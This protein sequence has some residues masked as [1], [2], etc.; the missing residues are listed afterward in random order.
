MSRLVFTNGTYRLFLASAPVSSLG[1]FT[2]SEL[3]YYREELAR[4][5]F[6][7][8]TPDT[9]EAASIRTWKDVYEDIK[10]RAR[11]EE[12]YVDGDEAIVTVLEF[13]SRFITP[14][15]MVFVTR[16]DIHRV[17]TRMTAATKFVLKQI[18]RWRNGQNYLI[19]PWSLTPQQ[20][21]AMVDHMV[22]PSLVTE[23]GD[24]ELAYHRDNGKINS[25]LN[26]MV[27]KVPQ[28][29]LRNLFKHT[30]DDR[31]TACSQRLHNYLK[32]TIHLNLDRLQM[33]RVISRLV[34]ISNDGRIKVWAAR[35]GP[36]NKVVLQTFVR[37]AEAL[38]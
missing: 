11:K 3:D 2:R 15:A 8:Y 21:R 18:Q 14:L 6:S 33:Y 34:S 27:F 31:D 22:V 30:D 20:M 7:W 13:L 26:M 23:F 38:G 17:F 9:A 16:N 1:S 32:R 24:I 35:A 5:V 29:T 37:L 4:L 28:D 25:R 12:M 10:T 36:N 19:E